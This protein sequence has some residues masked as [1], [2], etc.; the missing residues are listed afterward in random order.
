MVKTSKENTSEDKIRKYFEKKVMSSGHT[1]EDKVQKILMKSFKGNVEREV[2]FLDMDSN[3]GRTID[4]IAT[5][6]SLQERLDSESDLLGSLKIIIECKK[7][8]DHAWIFHG[9]KIQGRSLPDY[10]FAMEKYT[11]KFNPSEIPWSKHILLQA[12]SYYEEFIVNKKN[13]KETRSNSKKNNLYTAIMQTIKATRYYKDSITQSY[14]HRKNKFEL[15]SQWYVFQPLIVF[16]GRMYR[17]SDDEIKL[18]PIEFASM[19]KK[20]I[21]K[22]YHET[23]GE[24]HIVSINWLENYFNL[25]KSNYVY[26]S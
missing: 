25:L 11:E 10:T 2:P 6:N 19:Q 8:P 4:F 9:E 15:P 20:Y 26:D 22:Y 1:L 14:Q 23:I 17:T 13:N 21:S 16:Q 5:D 7:L 12:D 3:E 18:K 24:I